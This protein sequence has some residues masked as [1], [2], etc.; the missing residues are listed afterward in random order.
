MVPTT[1]Q[2]LTNQM[3]VEGTFVQI[4]SLLVRLENFERILSVSQC[5]VS[6][7][8]ALEYPK[9]RTNFTL[10]RFVAAPPAIVAPAER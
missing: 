5:K 9:L 2:E 8:G 1:V 6:A 10:S 4:L 3:I 7:G